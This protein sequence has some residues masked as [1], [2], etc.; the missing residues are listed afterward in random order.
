MFLSVRERG[1]VS[2]LSDRPA[3]VLRRGR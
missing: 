3:A 1:V 2:A